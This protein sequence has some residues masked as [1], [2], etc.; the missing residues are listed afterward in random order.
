MD[1]NDP[2]C[3][4]IEPE[5]EA[6]AS[7][8]W[9]HGLGADGNDFASIVPQ[10]G[11]PA[12]LPVRFVFP[13][14]PIRP[15]TING[16]AP[17]RAW[18]DIAR[19]DFADVPDVAGVEEALQRVDKLIAREETRGVQR[20]RIVIA[21]FSQGGAVIW[22]YLVKRA[23]GLAGAVA[24]STFHPAGLRGTPPASPDTPPVF[25]AHGLYDSTAALALGERTQAAFAR[26]GYRVEWHRYP[27][28]HQVCTE[29]IAD[30]GAWLRDVL[31][32]DDET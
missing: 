20:S 15:V 16:G 25:A 7:V 5:G 3:V 10:L 28:A 22:E 18:F 31:P 14:A 4:E 32:Q 21:G 24:L 26:A 30:L 9:L 1:N 8:I 11:L 19:L 29:E 2:G 12:D 13:H 23:T 6:T 17:M 27:M